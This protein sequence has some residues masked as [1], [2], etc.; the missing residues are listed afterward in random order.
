MT[1]QPLPFPGRRATRVLPFKALKVSPFKVPRGI[2]YRDRKGTRARV[3]RVP[4]ENQS[5]GLRV[6]SL[7][8]RVLRERAYKGL[9]ATRGK[10]FKVR[11]ATPFKGPRGTKETQYK[12]PRGK[13]GRIAKSLARKVIRVNPQLYPVRKESKVSRYKG[14]KAIRARPSKAPKERKARVSRVL[15]AIP[16]KAHKEIKAIVC[17]ALKATREMRVMSPGLRVMT[18]ARG[19]K[20]H[21]ETLAAAYSTSAS[22]RTQAG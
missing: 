22:E 13:T 15:K 3:F 7:P 21:R 9:R 19:L 17:R 11:R 20:G 8:F 14:L 5:K 1:V 4:K 16:S 6:R 18:E 10:A 2:Q 12:D